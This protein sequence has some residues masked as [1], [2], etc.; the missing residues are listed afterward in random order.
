VGE[1]VLRP[2]RVAVAEPD[3]SAPEPSTDG[4]TGTDP[5]EART[6]EPGSSEQA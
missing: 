1:R 4:E 3:G 5:V 2:A 6:D